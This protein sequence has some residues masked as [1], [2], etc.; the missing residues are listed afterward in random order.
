MKYLVVTDTDEIYSFEAK[1]QKE[2]LIKIIKKVFDDS[3]VDEILF[4]IL[5]D[6]GYIIKDIN[7]I[8]NE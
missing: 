2:L 5:S 4:G 1:D 8:I 3:D 7:K 6:W